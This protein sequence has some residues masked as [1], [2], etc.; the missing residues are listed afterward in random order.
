MLNFLSIYTMGIFTMWLGSHITMRKRGMRVVSGEFRAVYELATAM[1]K[2]LSQINK[3]PSTLTEQQLKHNIRKRLRGGKI[4]YDFGSAIPVQDISTRK[5][6]FQ[7]LK[8]QF[9]WLLAFVISGALI[10]IG[11]QIDARFWSWGV[12]ASFGIFI[13]L[14]IGTTH[15]S[16]LFFAFICCWW[17]FIIVFS[18]PRELNRITR[19]V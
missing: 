1:R 13:A 16:R 14:C 17:A 4:G 18:I 6:L 12:G 7:W 15:K 5:A 2:Q 11:L 8:K 10:F 3:D 9:W 19:P